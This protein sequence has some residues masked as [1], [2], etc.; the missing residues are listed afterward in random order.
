MEKNKKPSSAVQQTAISGGISSSPVVIS[1]REKTG[2]FLSP[3][4]DGWL[5][6]HDFWGMLRLGRFSGCNILLVIS[7]IPKNFVN[8]TNLWVRIFVICH[9]IRPI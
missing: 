7:F 1:Y 2:Q 5:S 9:D 8:R 4:R 3:T 6:F